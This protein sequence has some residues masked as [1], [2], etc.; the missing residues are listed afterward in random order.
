MAKRILSILETAYR[1]TLEEQDD[2]VIWL[3]HAMKDAGA[4]VTL[5]LRGAAV[6]YA[7]RGQDA[8]GLAFGRRRQTQPPRPDVELARLAKK[9]VRMLAIQEDTATRGLVADGL[10]EE[11]GLVPFAAVAQLCASHDQVWHW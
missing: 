8:A 9:G 7:A 2:T 3:M 4:D 11:V 5:V 1:A 6:N 10:I